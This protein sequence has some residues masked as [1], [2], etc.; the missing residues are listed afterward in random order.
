MVSGRDEKLCLTRE[1]TQAPNDQP[2]TSFSRFISYQHQPIFLVS[3]LSPVIPTANNSPVHNIISHHVPSLML[4]LPT[5]SFLMTL[6]GY[7]PLHPWDVI[8]LGHQGMMGWLHRQM[9]QV[10][11]ASLPSLLW[12]CWERCLCVLFSLGSPVLTEWPT[13]GRWSVCWTYAW[14]CTRMK[15]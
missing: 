11:C 13:G 15:E 6:L 4:L 12:A 5:R 14:M 1:G 7:L 9:C 3:R 2:A 10:V 8:S